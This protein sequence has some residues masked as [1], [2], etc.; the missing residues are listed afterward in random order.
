MGFTPRAPVYFTVDLIVSI[1]LC[2]ILPNNSITNRK[3]FVVEYIYLLHLDL[4]SI[5]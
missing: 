2:A 4:L 5:W 3:K 1:S